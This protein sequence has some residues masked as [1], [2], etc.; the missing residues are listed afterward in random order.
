MANSLSAEIVLPARTL[1]GV[2]FEH[3]VAS[4]TFVERNG[5]YYSNDILFMSARSAINESE[6]DAVFDYFNGP[7]VMRQLCAVCRVPYTRSYAELPDSSVGVALFNGTPCAYWLQGGNDNE[8]GTRGYMC[9]YI[10][11]NGRRFT[12]P[13]TVAL[14]CVPVIRVIR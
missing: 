11:R 5:D 12:A 1:Y 4:V 2:R 9:F 8:I 14:G 10:D 6:L 3:R 13:R 7:E